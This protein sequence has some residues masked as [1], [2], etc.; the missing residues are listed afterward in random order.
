MLLTTMIEAA[1]QEFKQKLSSYCENL[2]SQPLTP[3]L[4]EQVS[5]GLK[6]AL[7]AAGVAGFRTFLQGYEVDA[8]T[9]EMEG[10]IYRWK[11]VSAKTFL[12]PFGT[13]ELGRNLYQA[14][15]GGAAYVPLDVQWGMAGE[16]ATVEVREAVLLACVHITP[17]ESVQLLRKSALFTPSATAIK[18]IV[19]QTGQWLEGQGETLHQRLSQAEEVPLDTQVLV[20]SLDGVLVRLSEPGKKRGRPAERPGKKSTPVEPT[21]FQQ[22]MVGSLSYYGEKTPDQATPPRLLSRYVAQMPQAN[23][24][25]LKQ[26][27]EAEVHQAQQQL[28]PQVKKVLLLD[29]SPALWH[30]VEHTPLFDDYDQ[31]VD[32]YH[33]TEH[34]AKAAEALLGIGSPPAQHW[35]DQKYDWLLH[36]HR[37]AAQ[38]IKDIDA[39]VQQHRL[40][41]QRRKAINTERTFFQRN[42]ARMRYAAFRRQGLPIGS[43]PVEAA[44]KTL[45]KTRLG[46]AGMQWSWAGGQRIL[47]LRTFVKS[48][49]WDSFWR[50]YKQHRLQPVALA[51]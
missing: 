32:F 15:A 18:H 25:L 30:Y 19:A 35:Y 34:L 9:L 10:R 1:T 50:Y 38:I 13:M 26:R 40:S 21:S 24:P 49:R 27:F 28:P 47:Q 29:G 48:K 6:Q 46:R 20:A 12:T 33:T 39:Y 37:A 7:S 44:C 4:S 2:S 43:G 3:A 8:P 16:F 17:E 36:H 41:A 22:A 5:W 23:A 45:V 14:D 51:A 31:L 42:K 11:Q